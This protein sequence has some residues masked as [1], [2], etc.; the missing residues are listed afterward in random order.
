MPKP[1]SMPL[2][3]ASLPDLRVTT[4]PS[5]GQLLF[6]FSFH[7]RGLD[8]HGAG[9][10][11]AWL[12][13]DFGGEYWQLPALLDSGIAESGWWARGRDLMA[14][15]LS[16]SDHADADPEALTFELYET[17]IDQVRS[18]GYPEFLRIW[19][20]L[21][22]I[23][24][25]AGD[26]ERYRRFCVGRSRALAEAGLDDTA[27]CAATAIGGDEPRFRLFALAGRHPGRAID[28]P[29]QVPAWAYPPRYGPRSP[30]FARATAVM[31]SDQRVGLLISG[32]ASVVG[33]ATAHPGDVLAQTDEAATNVEALLE[34]AAGELA[35][36][37]LGLPGSDSLVRVY[38]RQAADWP[39]VEAR[40][41]RRWPGVRLAGLR[42]DVCRRDL[43][44]EMEAW[45]V[46]P[47]RSCEA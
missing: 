27:M 21:P 4:E 5:P 39:A 11:L 33:H 34:A 10:G 44:V 46:T 9:T 35:R 40:L 38:V 2:A 7:A 13:G 31:L 36:S 30:A 6:A 43:L 42:G 8:R 1:S 23:N 24:R 41:R 18:A 14:V 29:R 12:G 47:A 20:F 17:L 19:N 45:H 15:T 16:R 25:G 32:T 22:G 28:N 37:D 26:S 3:S